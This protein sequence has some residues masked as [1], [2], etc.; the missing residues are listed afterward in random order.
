MKKE[1]N[2]IIDA[3]HIVSIETENSGGGC[4]LDFVTLSNGSV[5]VVNDE[6]AGLYA[7]KEAFYNSTTSTKGFYLEGESC[8]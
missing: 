8:E 3:T 6:Y 5:L 4:W 1:L 7:S 2:N